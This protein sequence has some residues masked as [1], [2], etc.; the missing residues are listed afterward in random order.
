MHVFVGVCVLVPVIVLVGVAYG[1]NVEQDVG[2]LVGVNPGVS[3]LVDVCVLLFVTVL[4][5]VNVGVDVVNGV[6]VRVAVNVGVGV[7]YDD[8]ETAGA[9]CIFAFAQFDPRPGP[10]CELLIRSLNVGILATCIFI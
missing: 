5:T 9:P 7:G 6:Y 4:V 1:V 2:E 8:A 10:G 3:V